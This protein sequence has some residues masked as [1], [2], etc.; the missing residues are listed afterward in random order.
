M[1]WT[2][3]QRERMPGETTFLF[4]RRWRDIGQ[5]S[6][7][8]VLG[9]RAEHGHRVGRR[10]VGLRPSRRRPE[11]GG[12]Q[13]CRDR[14]QAKGQ[15]D[16]ER[17]SAYGFILFLFHGS[18][19]DGRAAAEAQIFEPSLLPRAIKPFGASASTIFVICSGLSSDRV[20]MK[21]RFVLKT[22]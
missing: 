12:Q 17:R 16:L 10:S 20:G 3:S 21:S 18:R 2:E 13:N 9:D 6:Q 22:R 4:L 11:G 1:D 15:C 14:Y 5:R 8:Q 7:V 19:M